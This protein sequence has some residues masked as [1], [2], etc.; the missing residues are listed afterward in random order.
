MAATLSTVEEYNPTTNTWAKKADMPVAQNRSL[1]WGG[2]W[3]IYAIGGYSGMTLANIATVTTVEEYDPVTDVWI[4][5]A[6]MPSPV[7]H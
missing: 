7:G 5:K 1:Y 6:D 4:K 3:K 2:E